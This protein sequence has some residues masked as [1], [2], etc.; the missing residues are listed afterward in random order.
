M[1]DTPHEVCL[2]Y[3]GAARP[4][5]G[6]AL[7]QQF[8]ILPD[9]LTAPPDSEAVSYSKTKATVVG[10]RY[11]VQATDAEAS[12]IT[13]STLTF[14]G[15]WNG[16]RERV[17]GWCAADRALRAQHR[18]ENEERRAKK[19]DPFRQNLEPLREAYRRARGSQRE[20]LIA[21]IV[22]EVTRP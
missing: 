10:A 7:L 20:Q 1:S 11:R 15:Q 9:N 18:S 2:L 3:I 13:P 16:D 14:A 22:A 8:L 19:M 6:R 5:K 4:A 17:V 21:C 12:R